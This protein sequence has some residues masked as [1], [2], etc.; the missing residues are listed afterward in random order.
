MHVGDIIIMEYGMFIPVDGII[1]TANQI[2]CD[3]SSITGNREESKKD[4]FAKC[5]EIRDKIV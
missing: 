3:E 1:V 2:S 4:T 5:I